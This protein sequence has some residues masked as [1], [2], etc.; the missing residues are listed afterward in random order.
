MNCVKSIAL[1]TADTETRERYLAKVN[2][3]YIKL[4]L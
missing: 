1:M 4:V 3:D 2:F